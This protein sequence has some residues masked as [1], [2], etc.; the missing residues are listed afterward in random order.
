MVGVDEFVPL[1]VLRLRSDHTPPRAFGIERQRLLP[2]VQL[3]GKGPQK[4]CNRVDPTRDK[5]LLPRIVPE[6]QHRVDCST[7]GVSA[8][9]QTT[10][11]GPIERTLSVLFDF[12]VSAP[13]FILVSDVTFHSPMYCWSHSCSSSTLG[14]DGES[15]LTAR[16][17]TANKPAARVNIVSFMTGVASNAQHGP[18]SAEKHRGRMCEANALQQDIQFF[19]AE[20]ALSVTE[21]RA[22]PPFG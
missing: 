11:N 22:T 9:S 12:V 6:R 18:S 1:A 13:G 20:H 8:P 4:R 2:I 16:T 7:I 19:L 14:V 21:I 10:H 3:T 5:R 17:E 15:S